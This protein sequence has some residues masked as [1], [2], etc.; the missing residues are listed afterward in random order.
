MNFIVCFFATWQT[1]HRLFIHRTRR[2]GWA[3]RYAA[4]SD[5]INRF[6]R[7]LADWGAIVLKFWLQID[8]EEQLRRFIEFPS[9]L[10]PQNS[11]ERK[12]LWEGF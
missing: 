3:G 5:E 2:A 4:N 7:R 1:P 6:E 11:E 8:Q 10:F 12:P 9:V